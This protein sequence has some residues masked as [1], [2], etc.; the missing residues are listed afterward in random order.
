ML[1][2]AENG[3]G[4]VAIALHWAVAALFVGQVALA[5][6]MTDLDDGPAKIALF[7]WHLAIG[8][9]ILA[10]AALRL[11]WRAANPVPRLPDTL[12]R[13]EK[14]AARANHYALYAALVAV[15][16]AGWALASAAPHGPAAEALAALPLPRLPL[17]QSEAAAEALESVHTNLAWAAVGLA[18]L[19]IAAAL[20]H[21]F[22]LRDDVLRRMLRPVGRRSG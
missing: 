14:R 4:L 2:N 15:P 20:R 1:R 3:Y 17:P 16:L 10:L 11:G 22:W 21:H 18:L 19:H 6:Q 5:T 13:W 8:L 7:G 12:R 9:A